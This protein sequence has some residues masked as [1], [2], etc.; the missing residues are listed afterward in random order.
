MFKCWWPKDLK[1][2]PNYFRKQTVQHLA[3][4]VLSVGIV[5][6]GDGSFIFCL[7]GHE[8]MG[9]GNG[10]L[11]GTMFGNMASYLS[12]YLSIMERQL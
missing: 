9:E 10:K 7:Y 12:T 4:T 1:S 11:L 2:D 3:L 8:E 6:M 5:A